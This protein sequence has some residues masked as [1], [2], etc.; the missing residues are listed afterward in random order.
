MELKVYRIITQHTDNSNNKVR[1]FQYQTIIILL[2]SIYHCE[3]FRCEIF[4]NKKK[5]NRV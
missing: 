3:I 4:R 5:H 2:S 1:Y